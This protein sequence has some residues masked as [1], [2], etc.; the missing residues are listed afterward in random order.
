MLNKMYIVYFQNK[1]FMV[2]TIMKLTELLERLSE[3]FLN[4]Y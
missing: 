4:N 1:C 3:I 2:S